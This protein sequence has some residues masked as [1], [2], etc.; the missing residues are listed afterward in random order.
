MSEH[1]AKVK[2]IESTRQYARRQETWFR[3][4]SALIP[5]PPESAEETGLQ[6]AALRIR[7]VSAGN[8]T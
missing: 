1:E 7:A 4:E 5:T 3:K 6:L 2:I 8:G